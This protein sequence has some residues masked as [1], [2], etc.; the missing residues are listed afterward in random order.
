VDNAGIARHGVDFRADGVW[1]TYPHLPI[2]PD[3]SR[4]RGVP[5]HAQPSLNHP[6]IHGS[7][8][9]ARELSAA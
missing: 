1:I 8:P 6:L 2:S 3:A 9:S 5:I 7:S 4:A